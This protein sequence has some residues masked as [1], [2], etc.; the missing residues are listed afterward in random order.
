MKNLKI[1]YFVDGASPTP[2]EFARAMQMNAQVCFRNARYVEMGDSPEQCDGVAGCIPSV[3][4]ACPKAEDV[5]TR[6]NAEIAS[7]ID[8]GGEVSPPEVPVPDTSFKELPLVNLKQREWKPN[9]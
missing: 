1:L 7:L 9:V 8:T 2:E 5:L 3:Y 4:A 6:R